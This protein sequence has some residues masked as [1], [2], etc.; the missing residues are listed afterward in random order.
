MK[1]LGHRVSLDECEQIL[2]QENDVVAACVGN[3]QKIVVFV[4][5]VDDAAPHAESLRKAIGIRPSQCEGRSISVIPRN[6]TGKIQYKLLDAEVC[7]G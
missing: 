7:C 4:E 5:G 1:L 6:E 2:L 3:D